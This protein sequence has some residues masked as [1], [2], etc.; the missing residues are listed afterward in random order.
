MLKRSL[1][2][3]FPFKDLE[4]HGQLCQP[5]TQTHWK[6]TTTA[7]PIF[8][9]LN[10]WCDKRNVTL[11][12]NWET[13]K[14]KWYSFQLPVCHSICIIHNQSFCKLLHQSLEINIFTKISLKLEQ[15]PLYY[16]SKYYSIRPPLSYKNK[17]RKIYSKSQTLQL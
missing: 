3:F 17:K 13:T 15:L 9:S 6:K 14:W 12:V 10:S 7:L 11:A 8:N 1:L 2:N 5:G 16:I 4:P